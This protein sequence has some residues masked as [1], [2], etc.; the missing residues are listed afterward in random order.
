MF[1]SKNMDDESNCQ[2][3]MINGPN[4]K[5]MGD[6]TDQG[7]YVH[8]GVIACVEDGDAATPAQEDPETGW[9]YGFPPGR[10]AFPSEGR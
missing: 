4:S 3:G 5:M 8:C 10:Q 7:L 9:T 1:L 6:Q 2:A